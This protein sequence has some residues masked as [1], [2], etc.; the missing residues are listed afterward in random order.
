MIYQGSLEHGPA[1]VHAIKAGTV[2]VL[3]VDPVAIRRIEGMSIANIRAAVRITEDN[4][5]LFQREWRRIDGE[6]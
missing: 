2:V 5:A 3:D 1:H 6:L 4:V